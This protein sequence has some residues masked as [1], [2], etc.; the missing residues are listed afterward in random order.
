MGMNVMV[1]F[2]FPSEA[3]TANGYGTPL[4]V[5]SDSR[6][7]GE[8]RKCLQSCLRQPYSCSSSGWLLLIGYSRRV[9]APHTREQDGCISAVE[10]A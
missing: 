8:L 2:T 1:L 3:A 6:G 10:E 5:G 4:D 9:L 7:Q